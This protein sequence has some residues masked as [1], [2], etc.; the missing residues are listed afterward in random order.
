[1]DEAGREPE[2]TA[3]EVYRSVTRCLRLLSQ[4]EL[5]STLGEL[6]LDNKTLLKLTLKSVLNDCD[7]DIDQVLISC[8]FKR[9][10]TFIN[11]LG[12]R[13]EL[14]QYFCSNNHIIGS[15]RHLERIATVLL[16]LEK[17]Q[18]VLPPGYQGVL[19]LW[20]LRSWSTGADVIVPATIARAEF[21]GAISTHLSI[22][23]DPLPSSDA[24]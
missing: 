9:N 7:I 12:E 22:Q 15:S 10:P 8:I 17:H 2:I 18:G 20:K 19:Y 6:V 3:L 21:A 23:S 16:T 4:T 1:M 13:I 14:K 11:Q 24:R 5:K